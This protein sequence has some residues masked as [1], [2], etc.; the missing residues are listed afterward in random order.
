MRWAHAAFLAGFS[1]GGAERAARD[2][3][4]VREATK[5]LLAANLTS[6]IREGVLAWCVERTGPR[7]HYTIDASLRPLDEAAFRAAFA[8]ALDEAR[9]LQ[10]MLDREERGLRDRELEDRLESAMLTPEGREEA[11]AK[12]R[13]RDAE[14]AR[15]MRHQRM[16]AAL[17]HTIKET[18]E[19]TLAETGSEAAAGEACVALLRRLESKVAAEA[20]RVKKGEA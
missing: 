1:A 3:A 15:W 11:R 9:R 13:A 10:P 14:M 19:R 20:R 6:E 5:E 12:K 2:F 17:T 16:R 7:E 8:T 18:W 4:V